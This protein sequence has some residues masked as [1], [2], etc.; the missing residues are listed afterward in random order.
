M[1]VEGTHERNQQEE[2]QLQICKERFA[3]GMDFWTDGN[4]CYYDAPGF[5]DTRGAALDIAKGFYLRQLGNSLN[6]LRI[7]LV[8]EEGSIE[9]KALPFYD[10][11][12][13][14]EEFIGK[15]NIGKIQNSTSIIVTK[16]TRDLGRIRSQIHK[17]LGEE[18]SNLSPG[19]QNFLEYILKEKR[20]FHKKQKK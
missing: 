5:D 6:S 12:S 18:N 17:F 3:N 13:R 10:L 1:I 4:L 14:F 19:I 8:T 15:G 20:P 7:V 11:M 9:G 2:F 16:S